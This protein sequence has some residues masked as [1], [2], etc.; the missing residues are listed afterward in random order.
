MRR[1]IG[2]RVGMFIA[3]ATGDPG[4]STNSAVEEVHVFHDHLAASLSA[5]LQ[6]RWTYLATSAVSRVSHLDS[7]SQMS[8]SS[9]QKGRGTG[10]AAPVFVVSAL[11]RRQAFCGEA[12]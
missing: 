6:R 7:S 8:T 9:P 4:Q 3:P 1:A 10:G 5:E 11:L 12:S 2:T